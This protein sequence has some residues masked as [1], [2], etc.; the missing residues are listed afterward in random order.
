MVL[1]TKERLLGGRV[2]REE[3]GEREREEDREGNSL[4]ELDRN[5]FCL[6]RNTERERELERE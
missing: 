4:E 3:D 5:C 2:E 1:G 6:D